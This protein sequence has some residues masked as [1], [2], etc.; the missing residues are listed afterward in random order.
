[1]PSAIPGHHFDIRHE[2]YVNGIALGASLSDYFHVDNRD[3]NLGSGY[4]IKT[5]TGLIFRQ[6]W[7][8]GLQ[9]ERYHIFTWKGYDPAVDLSTVD[10]HRLNVQGDAGNALLGVFTSCLSYHT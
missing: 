1:M 8:L 6:R 2:F 9:L 7:G 3:Y 10:Y 4:S 5:Y